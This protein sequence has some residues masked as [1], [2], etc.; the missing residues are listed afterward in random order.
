MN[1]RNSI[2]FVILVFVIVSC[3]GGAN[4]SPLRD[5]I[6]NIVAD[7]SAEVYDTDLDSI[8]TSNKICTGDLIFQ[9]GSSEFSGAIEDVTS[10]IFSHVGILKLSG[11]KV[12]VLEATPSGGVVLTP[13]E[14]FL[15][16]SAT[17][18]LGNPLVK[19]Y[20]LNLA[21]YGFSNLQAQ[22]F[23]NDA[24]DRASSHLGASY[25][26]AFIS[27]D[28]KYYCSELVYEAFIDKEGRNLF[29]R[30]P[31]NFRDSTGEISTYWTRYY[32]KLGIKPQQDSLGTNPNQ[33]SQSKLLNIVDVNINDYR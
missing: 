10:G 23:L 1:S 33:L 19:I 18:T 32:Q 13:F 8:F 28:D 11:N 2:L 6:D 26:F 24:V 4:K 21:S 12:F 22:Q 27:G 5:S 30:I 7:L 20:R 14:K 31:M 15:K 17:D 25:D 16:D 3:G 29:E 9:V